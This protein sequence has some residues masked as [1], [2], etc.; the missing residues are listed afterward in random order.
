MNELEL[1][2]NILHD[3]IH[4]SIL[5]LQRKILFRLQSALSRDISVMCIHIL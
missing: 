2:Y 3:C 1:E 5:T 4:V